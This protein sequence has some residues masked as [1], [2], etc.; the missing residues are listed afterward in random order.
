MRW[1]IGFVASLAL[2]ACD[3]QYPAPPDEPPVLGAPIFAEGELVYRTERPVEPD[4]ERAV[5]W[6]LWSAEGLRG[7]PPLVVVSHGGDGAINGH[8]RFEHL[9]AEYTARGYL[10]LHLNHAASPSGPLHR[11]DR[12]HDVRAAIDAALDGTIPLP[13]G[14]DGVDEAAIGHIGH[15]WGAY[16]AHAV[17][18]ADFVDPQDP[19]GARWNFRDPRVRAFVALSPQGPGG[20]GAFD[21][22]PVIDAPS[23]ANSWAVVDVP[24]YT[25]IGALE[26]D[27]VAGVENPDRCPDCFRAVDWRLFP[28]ARYPAD[29][30]RYATVVRGADHGA[31]GG[32]GP[33]ALQTYIAVNTR[34]FF[35]AWLRDDAEAEAR[36]GLVGP[37]EF[38]ENHRK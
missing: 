6:R 4:A 9:A 22:Q 14:V 23:A 29:G 15:S 16:T 24:V 2:V 20:F 11:W 12:P 33:A 10:T 8:R 21:V 1:P 26:M 17:G 30:R 37:A 7:S 13:D 25:L 5:R 36:I 27:G 19:D 3:G 34:L 32:D 31:M 28:F 38:T 35:D 18:G